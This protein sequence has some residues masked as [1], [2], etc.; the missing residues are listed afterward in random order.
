MCVHVGLGDVG[1]GDG[2][3]VQVDTLD[4]KT[5]SVTLDVDASKDIVTKYYMFKINRN[6]LILLSKMGGF[7]I[8][9]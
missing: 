5:H 1:W 4:A 8:L 7:K 2:V 6:F 9:T 3:L